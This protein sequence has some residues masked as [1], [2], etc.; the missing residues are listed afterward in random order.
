MSEQPEK[1]FEALYQTTQEDRDSQES[2]LLPEEE[3]SS[4]QEA[5]Q[6]V[7]PQKSM[8]RL[9]RLEKRKARIEQQMK[10]IHAREQEKVRRARTRRL[11]QI[12]A[13]ACKYLNCSDDIEPSEFEAFVKSLVEQPEVKRY[14]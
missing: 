7:V 11:I 3:P 5:T 9:E 2:H 4:A 8:S 6:P 1:R 14:I 13:L 12:G 10:A